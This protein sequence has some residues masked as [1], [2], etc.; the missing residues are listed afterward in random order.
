MTQLRSLLASLGVVLVAVWISAVQGQQAKPVEQ[1]LPP[2]QVALSRTLARAVKVA[3]PH[4]VAVRPR[5]QKTRARSAVVVAP[6]VVVTSADNLDVFGLDDLVVEDAQGRTFPARLRGRDLRLRLLVFR[7]P[8]LPTRPFPR[9]PAAG[10]RAGAFVLALGAPL[11]NRGT[12]TATF[13]IV[14]ATNRFQGRADQI[15]AALDASNSGGALVDLEGRLLGVLVYVNARLGERSGVG[16]AV[17]LAPID[18]AVPVLLRGKQLEAGWLGIVI[19]RYKAGGERGV[20]VI[21]LN[22]RGPAKAA[23]VA[24][25]DRIVSVAGRATPTLR[26]F[27]EAQ[28]YLYAKQA[29]E[30]VVQRGGVKRTIKL[31]VAKRP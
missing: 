27:R 7:C 12:P 11:R 23:G 1:K 4:L 22:S 9:A 6:G 30:L 20:E 29:I 31:Q 18:A 26:A 16:F 3:A 24:R 10:R 17:P 21:A 8:T 13:G 15:D 5:T 28:A 14:S 25:G 2:P 19:P